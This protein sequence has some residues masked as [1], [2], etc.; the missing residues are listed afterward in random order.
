LDRIADGTFE[1]LT[2]EQELYDRFLSVVQDGGHLRTPESLSSFK[3]SLSVRSSAPRIEA[4]YQFYNTS[5]QQSLGAAQDAVCPVWVHLEGKQYCSSALER[6]QQ[7]VLDAQDPRELPFDRILGDISLPPAVL[8]ADISAPMFRDFH[9]TLSGMAKQ[10]QISYRVRYRPPQHWVSRPLFVSGYGVELALKRTDYIVIDDRA[11]EKLDTETGPDLEVKEDAPDDLRPLSSSEVARLGVNSAKYVMDSADPL[12]ALI[13]LS[14]NFPKYSST[15][16]AHNATGEMLQEIRHNRAKMLPG[17]Y[18]VMWING[19]QIDTRQIDAFSLLEH[20]RRERKLIEK[21]RGLGLSANDAVKILSHQVLTEAQAGGEEQRYDYRDDS[22]EN[23]V[24]IWLNDL[25]KDSRYEGW[26]SE[27]DAVCALPR[28]ILDYANCQ[29][30][31][32]QCLSGTA[33]SSAQG[34]P[35]CGRSC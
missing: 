9:E 31:Y 2:T 4:H 3:L 27:L 1:D 11:A 26:S 29:L 32:Y 22:E 14:Q 33:A 20:L 5:V 30:V 12:E 8:Y 23:Q 13:K 19:V 25:E 18:N 7:D 35:Q 6:A 15:V 16:A 28:I 24:I 10:G 21:F 17:G 34:S